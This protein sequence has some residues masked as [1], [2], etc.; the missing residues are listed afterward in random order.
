MIA[1]SVWEEI[2]S[3]IPV[4]KS[5]VGRPESDSKKVLS[6]ILYVL[7]TGCQWRN[8]PPQF[9]P[10]S[11]VHG[12]F[13]KWICEGVFERIMKKARVL[14]FRKKGLISNWFSSDTRSCKAPFA[15]WGGPNPTDRRKNGV[16]SSSIVDWD[17]APLSVSVG[18]ANM[19]DSKFLK[20]TFRK[21][22]LPTSTNVIILATDAA[23]DSKALRALLKKQNVVL[24]SATNRRRNKEST[25]YKPGHRWVAERT[26]GWQVWYRGLKI[27]W[28]KTES[29]FLANLQL[30]SSLQLFK[31]A[32]IFG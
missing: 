13:R 5:K 3:E 22:E 27:C 1:D 7:E 14:Y 32:G 18:P 15:S 9:G 26:W 16:K 10:K 29:A 2:K 8:L 31:M 12:K 23:Y 17:G 4:K 11:T 20:K 25:S 28:T 6:G 30:A 19:H 21:H 24:L